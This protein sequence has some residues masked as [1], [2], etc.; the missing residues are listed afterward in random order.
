MISGHL[1]NGHLKREQLKLAVWVTNRFL[2]LLLVGHILSSG[3][4]L[5]KSFGFFFRY[6]LIAALNM[7]D[8]SHVFLAMSLFY[9]QYLYSVPRTQK[10][11]LSSW[12][13]KMAQGW[14][15]GNIIA[16][17]NTSKKGAMSVISESRKII[18]DGPVHGVNLTLNHIVRKRFFLNSLSVPL[19]SPSRKFW[20]NVLVISLKHCNFNLIGH[21]GS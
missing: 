14:P 20:C 4:R 19:V 9:T 6:Q 13:R 1:N 8:V 5:F 12:V 10:S 3:I 2:N 18:L 11:S 17:A 15:W 21:C 16:Q 7:P